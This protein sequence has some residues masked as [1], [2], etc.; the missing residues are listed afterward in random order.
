[1]SDFLPEDPERRLMYLLGLLQGTL[2][3]IIETPPNRLSPGVREAIPG[4]KNLVRMIEI[5]VMYWLTP[6]DETQ[7]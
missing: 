1:M 6:E 2:T 7:K 3:T 5:L 4:L